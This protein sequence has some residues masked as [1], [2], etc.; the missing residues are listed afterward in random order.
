M[1]F[2]QMQA[3]FSVVGMDDFDAPMQDDTVVADDARVSSYQAVLQEPMV[4]L[5]GGTSDRPDVAT[6]AILGYN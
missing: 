3:G 4:S 6:V 5:V 1:T 2:S